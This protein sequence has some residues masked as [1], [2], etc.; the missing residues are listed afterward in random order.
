[1]KKVING[2]LCDTNT[3]KLLG[4]TSYS[5]R[6][7]FHYW[8]EELYITKS[9]KYFLYG[10]G[11]PASRYA[12]TI[13]QN[14]WSGGEAIQLLDRD[15]AMEWAEEHLTGDEYIAA[16]GN[17]EDDSTV[18]ICVTVPVAVKNRMEEL[19]ATVGLTFGEIVEAAVMGY[20]KEK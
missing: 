10:E 9:G 15:A 12:K 14:E 8:S 20:D 4:E 7:D 13:G 5:N 11:G 1:M 6:R 16:F 17:P 18:Q 2:T 19:R 3:A